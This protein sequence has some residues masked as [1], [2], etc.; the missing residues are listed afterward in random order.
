MEMESIGSKKVKI[1]A[2]LLLATLLAGCYGPGWG[3]GSPGW[4][5]G[6]SSGYQTNNYYSNNVYR[7]Y[8]KYPQPGLN[9]STFGGYVPANQ[10]WAESTRGR[11]S[12]GRPTATSEGHT[13]VAHNSGGSAGH[14]GG[15]S[16]GHNGGASVGHSGGG[17]EGG[18]EHGGSS[19]Y[20]H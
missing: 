15:E 2:S 5:G 20:G 8:D 19:G 13:V 1:L 16:S 7:G 6:E 17:T 18:A 3:G 10:A 4:W 9:R 12:Y 14:S 11:T